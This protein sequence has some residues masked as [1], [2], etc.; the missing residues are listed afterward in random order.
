MIAEL[1]LSL[2]QLTTASRQQHAVVQQL[3][4]LQRTPVGAVAKLLPLLSLLLSGY[5]ADLAPAGGAGAGLPAALKSKGG[6]GEVRLKASVDAAP[7]GMMGGGNCTTLTIN[8]LPRNEKLRR[9]SQSTHGIVVGGQYAGKDS[10]E[11]L[12]A[13]FA[14]LFGTLQQ[15]IDGN[16]TVRVWVPEQPR[17]YEVGVKVTL[18]G[19][20]ASHWQVLHTGGQRKVRHHEWFSGLRKMQAPNTRMHGHAPS[21]GCMRLAPAV[22]IVH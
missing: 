22:Y 4:P 16:L 13:N 3:L 5:A 19:D 18:G 11:L 17:P 1:R 10:Y 7:N 9:L 15:L 12:K 6:Q 8:I 14:P 21:T 20:M 2:K